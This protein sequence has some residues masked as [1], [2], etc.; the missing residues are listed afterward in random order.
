M[1]KE[2]KEK[3]EK[4]KKMKNVIAVKS[5]QIKSYKIGPPE[6]DSNYT[7]IEWDFSKVSIEIQFAHEGCHYWLLLAR[8]TEK[9]H[10]LKAAI[11]SMKHNEC[12]KNFTQ[13]LT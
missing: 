4:R 5:A 12:N 11:L 2:L 13:E 10:V 3:K 8:T 7:S 1:K 6:I 9:S